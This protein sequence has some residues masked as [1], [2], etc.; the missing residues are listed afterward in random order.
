[1]IIFIFYRAQKFFQGS[2]N[3]NVVYIVPPAGRV[4][5]PSPIRQ[6]GQ[7]GGAAHPGPPIWQNPDAKTFF[8]RCASDLYER[9]PLG[10]KKTRPRAKAA[11]ILPFLGASRLT[12]G[13]FHK[14]K[15]INWKK[16]TNKLIQINK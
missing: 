9:A 5:G 7:L 16:L 4:R 8:C 10:V 6:P 3:S 14:K 15:E 2:V 11:S 12:L 13:A 1:M